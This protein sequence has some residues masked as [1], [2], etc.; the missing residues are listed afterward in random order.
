MNYKPTSLFPAPIMYKL[1]SPLQPHVAKGLPVKLPYFKPKP[2]LTLTAI[3]TVSLLLPCINLRHKRQLKICPDIV[4][5]NKTP[6][7]KDFM[8]SKTRGGQRLCLVKME[9]Q[10]SHFCFWR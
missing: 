5:D 6:E 9:T 4:L 10:L 7:V 8:L 3:H 2:L 1:Y